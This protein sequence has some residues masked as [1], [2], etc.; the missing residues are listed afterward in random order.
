MYSVDEK[1]A[2]QPVLVLSKPPPFDITIQVFAVDG[3]ATGEC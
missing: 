3:S 1:D 2:L